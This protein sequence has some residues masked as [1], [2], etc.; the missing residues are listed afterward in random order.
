MSIRLQNLCCVVVIALCVLLTAA[1]SFGEECRVTTTVR[2]LDEHGNPV[3]S[4]APEQLRAEIGDSLA[5]VVSVSEGAKPVT[6]LLIDISSSME[7]TWKQSVIA[8]KQLSADAGNRVAIA[9]F[10]ERILAHASGPEATN[11]LLDRLASMKTSMGGTALYD[12]VTEMAGAATNPD[13]VLVVITDGGDNASRH[14]SEQTVSSFLKNRWPPVFGLILDYAH[15]HLHRE[16]FKKIVVATGGLVVYPSS[17]SK[18]AEA[19]NELSAVVNAPLMV[20]LEKSQP[21]MKPEK[22]KFEVVGPDGKP[23]HDIQITHAAE[24]AACD[25]TPAPQNPSEAK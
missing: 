17:A 8:A 22:L 20:T 2:L 19:T 5:K 7:K 23:R 15:D 11:D 4:V 21:I 1:T 6:L 14:S 16:Y 25:T 3:R 10:R 24:V 9:V 12:S 18:V 13:T